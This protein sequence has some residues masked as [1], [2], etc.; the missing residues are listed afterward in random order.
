MFQLSLPR[1]RDKRL[2]IEAHLR[3]VQ[4]Q[5]PHADSLLKG[6]VTGSL[7]AGQTRTFSAS[8]VIPT[9]LVPVEDEASSI[10]LCRTKI[11]SG[12]QLSLI[13]ETAVQRMQLKRQKQSLTVNGIGKVS[14]TYNSGSVTLRLKPKFGPKVITVNAFI[15]PNSTQ[16][17]PNRSF[18]TS[19]LFHMKAIELADPN[20]NV[21]NP[22]ELI[23]G[24]DVAEEIIL[25]GKFT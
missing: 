23:L 16:L 15:L 4:K 11:D 13:S 10:I 24:S 20:S 8:N 18:D 21:S 19:I 9:A 25:D 17:L 6:E 2:Q 14:K 22:I 3:N 12:S 7:I 5:T 1:T